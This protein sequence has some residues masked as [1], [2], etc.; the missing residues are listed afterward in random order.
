MGDL[1][2]NFE[3]KSARQRHEY[4]NARLAALHR[5]LGRARPIELAN[6]RP[7][8][9]AHR[10][11]GRPA[12][13]GR[14]RKLRYTMLGPW[15]SQPEA[16]VISYESELGKALLGQKVGDK[17]AVRA[18]ASDVGRPASPP[19]VRRRRVTPRE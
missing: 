16:G 7:L 1:R 17:L 9:G 18:S 12:C 8:R 10:H 13:A 11:R 3:Y 14:R 5:D 2:E 15:E 19:R 4:L 6:H